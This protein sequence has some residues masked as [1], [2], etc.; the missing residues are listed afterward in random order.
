MIC[1][2]PI[3]MKFASVRVFFWLR[4]PEHCGVCGKCGNVRGM[5]M[6]RFW[7]DT[8]LV[9]MLGDTQL[10]FAEISVRPSSQFISSHNHKLSRLS[11]SRGSA[12][13]QVSVST[14]AESKYLLNPS[15]IIRVSS[16]SDVSHPEFMTLC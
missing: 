5:A 4:E 7:S 1:V 14:A 16:R 2:A 8:G 11:Y 9:S 12:C 3:R 15:L 13:Q 6:S 10:L